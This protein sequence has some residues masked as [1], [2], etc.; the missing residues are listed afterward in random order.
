MYR[1]TPPGREDH[2]R[3]A[4][5]PARKIKGCGVLIP[6]A[7]LDGIVDDAM[8]IDDSKI[9]EFQFQAGSNHEVELKE[10]GLALRDLPTR[11]LSEDDEDAERAR[12]RSERARVAALP[13]TADEWVPVELDETYAQR[14]T[15]SDLAGKRKMLKTTRV[16]FMWDDVDGER[17]PQV[18][19]GPV[20]L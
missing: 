6:V 3:C 11:D 13:A 2:Y 5:Y 17:W 20:E 4:G 7:E 15:G 18:T 8:S 16:S 9:V 10:I 14:W 19:I 12:L 1:V